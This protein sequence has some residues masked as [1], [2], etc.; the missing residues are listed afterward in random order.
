MTTS[1]A[2]PPKVQFLDSNG[3]PLVGGKVYTYAAGTT[4][5]LATYQDYAGNIQNTNPVILDS[6]GEA[7]IWYGAG[8]YKVVLKDSTDYE[9]WTVDNLNEPNQST[10]AA[11]SGSG[12]SALIGFIQ[13]GSGAVTRT[14]QSKLRDALNVKDFGAVGDGLTDDTAALQAAITAAG[15]S[16]VNS[17]VVTVP[18]GVYNFT[19]LTMASPY[20]ELHLESGASI[21]PQVALQKAI[22]VTA[23][24]C[25]ITGLGT[26]VSP[27][28]F[29]GANERTTYATVWVENCLGFRADGVTFVNTP[30]SSLFF[31]DSTQV[32]ITNVVIDGGYPYS[33]YNEGTT[34]A[35]CAIGYNPPPTTAGWS[36]S[37]IIDGCRISGCIQGF[38]PGN[39]DSPAYMSGLVV[40]GNSFFNCWDHGVYVALGEGVVVSGNN[41]TDVRRCI[42]MDGRNGVVVGNSLYSSNTGQ[43]NYETGV[44]IRNAYNAVVSGNSIRGVG[45]FIDCS[46]YTSSGATEIYGNVIANN[47]IWQTAASAYLQSAIRLGSFATLCVNNNISNNFVYSQTPGTQGVV[48]MACTSAT[49]PI[50]GINN[51]LQ[52]NIIVIGAV[53]YGL[54]ATDMYNVLVCGNTFNFQCSA[55]SPTTIDGFLFS[56]CT[57]GLVANNFI[58]FVSAGTNIT[59]RAIDIVASNSGLSVRNNVM[60]LSILTMTAPNYYIINSGTN[61]HLDSNQYSVSAPLSGIVSWPAGQATF[62]TNTA[63]CLT[64]STIVISPA[65]IAAANTQIAHGVFVTPVNGRFTIATADGSA[66]AGDWYWAI[67]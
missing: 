6:R 64:T 34:T 37:F 24:Y 35:Q 31:E 41:F 8:Q 59:F 29:N 53:N 44:S 46:V 19:Q 36:Y 61:C 23:D 62:D 39:Y 33:S 30:R 1:L 26:I 25:A 66:G 50:S 51:T 48:S 45:A 4:T 40:T 7:Q 16:A 17:R 18:K 63:N 21:R 65:T 57:N 67:R 32:M 38:L 27:A 22:I 49:T 11:L 56:A 9:I 52:N 47:S 5:P 14:V 43:L 60:D 15:G 3:N 55:A 20:V 54:I 28:V 42:V 2:T 13:A 58:N 12:G 10:L